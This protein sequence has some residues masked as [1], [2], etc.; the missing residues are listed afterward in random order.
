M[1]PSGSTL[2]FIGLALLI[3]LYAFGYSIIQSIK[4]NELHDGVMIAGG[5]SIFAYFLLLVSFK[6]EAVKSKQFLSELFEKH[7]IK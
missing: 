6:A 2:V 1:R 5:M 3:C 4:T 7:T